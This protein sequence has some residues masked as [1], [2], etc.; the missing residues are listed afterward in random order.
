M[1]LSDEELEELHDILDNYTMYGEDRI[2]Y[3]AEGDLARA[4]ARKVHDEAKQRRFW[5]AR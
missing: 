5:W 2:V 3:T 1:E 4:I